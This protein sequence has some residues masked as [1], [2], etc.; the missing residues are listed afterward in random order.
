MKYLNT[1]KNLE[2]DKKELLDNIWKTKTISFGWVA[3]YNSN[4]SNGIKFMTQSIFSHI[5][6][7]DPITKNAIWAEDLIW[8]ILKNYKFE[9]D[10]FYYV[11]K[12]LDLDRLARIYN[13]SYVESIYLRIGKFSEDKLWTLK[14][15]F[16]K[17]IEVK[18]KMESKDSLEEFFE[19]SDSFDRQK[20]LSYEK[21]DKFFRLRDNLKKWIV[22]D[23]DNSFM[24]EYS[25]YLKEFILIWLIKNILIS[26]NKS[27][28]T[29]WT[30]SISNSPWDKIDINN[31]DYF[32]SEFVSESMLWAGIY[33]FSIDTKA[34]MGVTPG[35]IIDSAILY[36]KNKT[37]LYVVDNGLKD[38]TEEV[39]NNTIKDY[40]ISQVEATSIFKSWKKYT[41][42][43]SK[44]LLWLLMNIQVVKVTLLLVVL[45]LIGVYFFL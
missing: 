6:F 13:F 26:I 42:L 17:H 23:Y 21:I 30:M 16:A 7:F 35:D 31:K 2:E 38:V 15:Y 41:N 19:I 24:E 10:K 20:V 33:P 11:S 34:P 44:S 39:G 9:K 28:D 29:I 43:S 36:N 40:I 45:I 32:C 5:N 18:N 27:Y 22:N 1:Y 8:V 37:K 14:K 25:S 12:E 3:N 4:I